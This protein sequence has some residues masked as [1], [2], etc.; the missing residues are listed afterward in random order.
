MYSFQAMSTLFYIAGLEEQDIQRAE[1]WFAFVERHLSRFD[2]Q[3]ELSQLNRQQGYPFYAS[4]LLY[5][6]MSQA[7]QY[8]QRTDHLFDPFMGQILT[9][10]GYPNQNSLSTATMPIVSL[11]ANEFSNAAHAIT[12]TMNGHQWGDFSY[13]QSH[14]RICT[15]DPILRTVHVHADVSV[16][17]GG[18]AKGWS[19]EQYALMMRQQ[20]VASGMVNAGGDLIIWGSNLQDYVVDVA[21]PWSSGQH[22]ASLHMHKD[23]GVATSSTIKRSW[24][25]GA[26][27]HHH[28]LDPR[29]GMPAQSDW[30]QLTVISDSLTDAEVYAKCVLILGKQQGPAWLR[31]QCPDAA[32]IGVTQDGR[33]LIDGPLDRYVTL[34]GQGEWMNN[35]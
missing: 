7:I 2:P 6:A 15:L 27:H 29:T 34:T 9:R 25:N 18:I 12:Q 11:Q 19:A 20:G 14:G 16:D 13:M 31:R 24:Q 32:M 28:L 8:Q 35:E 4:A 23:A 3:S 10:I 17:L 1:S 5:E 30:V 22:I 33:C 21:D 26:G